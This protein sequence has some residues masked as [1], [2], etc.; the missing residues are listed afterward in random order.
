MKKEFPY[1]SFAAVPVLSKRPSNESR[2][3]IDE[4][5]RRIDWY[6]EELYTLLQFSTI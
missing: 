4:V 3:L 2:D 6:F 1:N 5:E